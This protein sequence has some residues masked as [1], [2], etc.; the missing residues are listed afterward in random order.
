[1]EGGRA[2]IVIT[3]ST[4]KTGE[5]VRVHLKHWL[6]PQSMGRIVEHNAKR[7]SSH[8]WLVVFDDVRDGKGFTMD[9]QEG[10]FLWLAEDQLERLDD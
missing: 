8:K 2:S 7:K 9:G 1:M 5:T 4:F 6:R 3:M 10:Q